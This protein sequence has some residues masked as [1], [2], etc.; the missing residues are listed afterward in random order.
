MERSV[1]IH[2]SVGSESPRAPGVGL[3]GGAA[4]RAGAEGRKPGARE[5]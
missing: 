3:E 2:E 4:F 5:T 1:G